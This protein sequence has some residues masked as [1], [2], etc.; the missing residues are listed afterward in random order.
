VRVDGVRL[1]PAATLLAL[2]MLYLDD[3]QAGCG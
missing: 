3:R 2:R 1:A